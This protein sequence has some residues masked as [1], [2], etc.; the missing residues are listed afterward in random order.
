LEII[1]EKKKQG[2]ETT[3]HG[4]GG[5]RHQM[6]RPGSTEKLPGFHLSVNGRKS[7]MIFLDIPDR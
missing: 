7:I 3:P 1:S 2:P 4:I 6:N 5:Q